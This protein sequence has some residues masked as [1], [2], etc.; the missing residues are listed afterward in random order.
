MDQ[1]SAYARTIEATGEK[2]GEIPQKFGFL[3][4]LGMMGFAIVW[5]ML[6]L[7]FL[8]T[9]YTDGC[10]AHE[11][12]YLISMGKYY[13]WRFVR[14]QILA[15]VVC[16]GLAVM[17]TSLIAAVVAGSADIEKAG[18]WIEAVSFFLATMLLAKHIALIPAV[19]IAGNMMVRESI[20][21]I[22]QYSITDIFNVVSL[23][24]VAMLLGLVMSIADGYMKTEGPDRYLTVGL[25]G[26]L[27]SF[28]LLA[29]YLEGLRFLAERHKPAPPDAQSDTQSDAPPDAPPDTETLEKD[30]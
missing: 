28:M 20:I 24:A 3:L 15:G 2:A 1:I 13:F 6:Y 29:V 11:P 12:A 16:L 22:R 19:M 30:Y 7:G 23:Y 5:Q 21:A 4:G 9:A 17:V 26:L 18:V 27:M 25:Q 8:R 10:T 14:F